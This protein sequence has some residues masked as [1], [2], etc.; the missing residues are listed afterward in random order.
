M[1]RRDFLL[2]RTDRPALVVELSCRQLYMRYLDAQVTGDRRDEDGDA[3][4]DPW[5]SEPPNVFEE[6][7]FAD[8]L[9]ALDSRLH[10]VDVVRL[11]ETEWLACEEVKRG[12]D[13]VLASFRARGGRVNS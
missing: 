12:L 2:L 1:N 6:R 5:G 4:V 9:R 10:D 13:D 3:V 7:T 8:V 11:G